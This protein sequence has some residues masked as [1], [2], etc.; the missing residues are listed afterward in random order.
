MS[1]PAPENEPSVRCVIDIVLYVI[2]NEA[3]PYP[4]PG[5]DPWPL[6]LQMET[7]LVYLPVIH[8]GKLQRASGNCDYTLWYGV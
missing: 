4:G 5:F 6:N 1:R 2:L 8:N 7:P 3:I